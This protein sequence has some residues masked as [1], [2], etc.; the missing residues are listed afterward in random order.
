MSFVIH[1]TRYFFNIGKWAQPAKPARQKMAQNL[2]MMETVKSVNF[3]LGT[4]NFV[5]TLGNVSTMPWFYVV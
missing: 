5:L 1:G 4:L 2:S 3:L